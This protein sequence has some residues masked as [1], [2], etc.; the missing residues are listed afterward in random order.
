VDAAACLP[1][2]D[3]AARGRISGGFIRGRSFGAGVGAD[4]AALLL[5][6][7]FLIM[8]VLLLNFYFTFI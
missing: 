3:I 2:I 5:F 1:G 8:F 7:F 4:P 6:S